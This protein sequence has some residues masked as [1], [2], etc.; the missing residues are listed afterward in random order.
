MLRIQLAIAQVPDRDWFK[1][2]LEAGGYE[3]IEF[4]NLST[5]ESYL[6]AEAHSHQN[7]LSATVLITDADFSPEQ[8]V[9]LSS[10]L[11]TIFIT[12]PHQIDH[13]IHSR[14]DG[15]RC[16]CVLFGEVLTAFDPVLFLSQ[17]LVRMPPLVRYEKDIHVVLKELYTNAFD[18]GV[19]QLDSSCKNTAEEFLTYY[20]E[21]DRRIKTL[22]DGF[23][24]I[25][26]HGMGDKEQGRLS[27]AVED[28]GNGFDFNTQLL[29]AVPNADFSGRGISLLRSLCDTVE[30]KGCGNVVAV[31]YSWRNN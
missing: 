9:L 14:M 3:C 29:S 15:W 10:K 21:R 28:S 2:N 24:R 11:S 30:F 31:S 19:L 13:D 5:I 4:I 7:H 16:Q 12:S 20:Q 25:N 22:G 26:L 23:V 8:A 6:K 18:H 1:K 17:L 27:I